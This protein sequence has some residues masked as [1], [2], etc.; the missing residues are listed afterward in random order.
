MLAMVAESWFL[1]IGSQAASSNSE[2]ALETEPESKLVLPVPE[3]AAEK[4]QTKKSIPSS[5]P[6]TVLL[7]TL[8]AW[9]ASQVYQSY[10]NIGMLA[11][12][13]AHQAYGEEEAFTI[14]S[15][16]TG[17]L[18]MMDRQMEKV[19][20]VIEPDDQQALGKIRQINHLLQAQ[21]DALVISWETGD[22]NKEQEY[23]QVRERS[24]ESIQE[25]LGID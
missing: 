13:V 16:L 10:L 24:W 25:I 14:L 2:P 7:E 4:T 19:A 18:N 11:D 23:L 5:A 9:S 22:P 3:A 17:L 15:T 8:G 21:T 6:H 12:S 1:G 20:Q